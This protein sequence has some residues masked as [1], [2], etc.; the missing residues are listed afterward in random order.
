MTAKK[1][2][3]SALYDDVAGDAAWANGIAARA[4]G[5]DDSGEA[6]I[7]VDPRF[8]TEAGIRADDEAWDDSATTSAGSR[9]RR[10]AQRIFVALSAAAAIVAFV[11][12]R[13]RRRQ[14]SPAERLKSKALGTA[15]TLG[16]HG[17][18]IAGH[19]A[20]HGREIAGQAAAHGRELA[21]HRAEDVKKRVRRAVA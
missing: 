20:A 9:H 6:N 1:E 11:V 10:G 8:I 12:I 19:A 17:F 5:T 14:Q 3:S 21:E 7:P 4:A 16:E 2:S 15:Q 13:R 18:D